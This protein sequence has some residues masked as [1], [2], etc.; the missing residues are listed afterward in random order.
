MRA[1]TAWP[2]IL[3]VLVTEIGEGIRDWLRDRRQQRSSSPSGSTQAEDQQSIVR[4]VSLL[5]ERLLLE[6]EVE[7]RM[8]SLQESLLAAREELERERRELRQEK[9]R[10][11]E[12]LQAKAGATN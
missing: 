11:A 12:L 4:R 5:E 10:L 1:T 2:L 9:A 6:L 7:K 3:P 8:R